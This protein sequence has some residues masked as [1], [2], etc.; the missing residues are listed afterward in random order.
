MYWFPESPLVEPTLPEGYSY[1]LFDPMKDVH[2][3]CE[4]LRGGRLIDGLSDEQA[5]FNEIIN[6][7]ELVPSTDIHFLDYMGEH[8]G[9]ATGFEIQP[10]NSGDMHQVGIREDFRGKGLAKYLSYAVLSDLKARG[11][12]FVAL[13]TGESRPAAVKSYLRA[14]FLPVEYDVDM[15]TRWE[16]MLEVLGI[17]SVAMVNDDGSP[18]KTIYRTGL[19]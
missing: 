13:T 5:Y 15:V 19:K 10:G 9:T 2:A 7:K 1:S 4:C 16:N 17:D 18:Y 6:I 3:W 12:R 8:V 11:L 14:G